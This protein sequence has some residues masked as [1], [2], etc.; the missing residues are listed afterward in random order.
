MLLQF[1]QT[2]AP[3]GERREGLKGL[4]GPEECL[5][6]E[7]DADTHD[8]HDTHDTQHGTS[9]QK[10]QKATGSLGTAPSCALAE[11]SLTNRLSGTLTL[12]ANVPNGRSGFI[13]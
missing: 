4:M 6:T 9:P 5:P 7:V 2:Q 12:A 8:T 1:A 11:S 10:T 3:N 13:A